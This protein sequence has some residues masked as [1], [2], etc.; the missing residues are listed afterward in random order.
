MAQSQPTRSVHSTA[1]MIPTQGSGATYDMK[2]MTDKGQWVE[3]ELE[4]EAER[5]YAQDTVY[6]YR[7]LEKNKIFFKKEN[8]FKVFW[9]NTL[10]VSSSFSKEVS[11][12]EQLS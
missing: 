2:E 6:K 10:S 3:R 1:G 5:A 12:L 4:R 8:T 9:T 7:K 11:H